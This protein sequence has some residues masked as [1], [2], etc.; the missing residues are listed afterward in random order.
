MR[1]FTHVTFKA[2]TERKHSVELSHSPLPTEPK[3]QQNKKTAE[4]PGRPLCSEPA[5]QAAQGHG[6]NLKACFLHPNIMSGQTALHP[7]II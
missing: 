1:H 4:T 7:A 6:S 3:L 2:G 5:A